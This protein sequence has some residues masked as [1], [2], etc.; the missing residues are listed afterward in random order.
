MNTR[1]RSFISLSP[2]DRKPVRPNMRKSPLD[3]YDL[4]D[5]L[6]GGPIERKDWSTSYWVPILVLGGVIAAVVL[7]L[8]FAELID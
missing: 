7:V 5:Q 8:H 6:R 3:L 2:A 1:T 4:Q